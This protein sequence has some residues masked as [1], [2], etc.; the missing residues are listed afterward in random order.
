MG[1]VGQN[2]AQRYL[3]LNLPGV[4]TSQMSDNVKFGWA[5]PVA[6]P[7]AKYDVYD[8][9]VNNQQLQFVFRSPQF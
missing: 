7:R 2:Q 4:G 1:P 5:S 6:A 3:S 8:C 9:L